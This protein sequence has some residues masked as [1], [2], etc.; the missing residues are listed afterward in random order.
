MSFLNKIFGK[1]PSSTSTSHARDGELITAY[2]KLGRELQITRKDWRDSVL[3]GSIK[4]NWNHPDGLYNLIVQALQ[5][6][7]VAEVEA[8]AEQ[9]HKI[10]INPLRGATILGIVYLDLKKLD[11]AEKVLLDCIRK[12]GKEGYVL[13][14]LAKVYSAKGDERKSLSTLWEGLQID[15]N[16]DN[17]L[18]WYEV[19]HRERDGEAAGIAALECVAQIKGSWRAQLWLARAALN[20]K[21]LDLAIRYYNQSLESAETPSPTDLLM[22]MSGDLGNKG[23]LMPILDLVAPRF[24]PKHHGLQVGNNLI[25]A[26][27]DTGNLDAASAILRELEKLQRPDWRQTLGYWETEIAKIRNEVAPAT[28]LE[29][30][31]IALRALNGPLAHKPDAP[32]AALFPQKPADAPRLAFLGS[33][34][35]TT[36]KTD[37]QSF[38]PGLSDNPGRF[39]RALP[40][41]FSEYFH[42]FTNA[43]TTDLVPWI[44]SPQTGFVLCG[45]PWEDD[46]AAQHARN[47]SDETPIDWVV[48]SHLTVRG[49]NWKVGTRVIRTID[50]K[51]LGS[52]EYDIAEWQLHPARDQMLKDLR[53]ILDPEAGIQRIDHKSPA[54]EVLQETTFD[55]YVFQLEQAL[56]ARCDA[57]NEEAPSNLNNVPDIID[58]MLASCAESPLHILTR[59]CL[60]RTLKALNIKYTDLIATYQDKINHLQQQ[61]P[62]DETAQGLVNQEL[63]SLFNTSLPITGAKSREI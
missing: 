31:K 21:D 8:A 5:D 29:K 49:E 61:H 22:Q 34:A 42:L 35:T 38:K 18:G 53:S 41:F 37:A 36:H 62:L 43:T 48:V 28:P 46:A 51:C 56:A 47:A 12:H 10:D 55:R 26:Y 54:A 30:M 14:N 1:I 16:Q 15:P 3:M 58:G 17:G 6:E 60:L 9:L 7:F 20:E 59:L 27:V 11:A 23:H 44:E 33:S 39:S 13:T 19:I 2:D 32:S 4:E 57:M 40:L 52:F 24:D 25:K 50:A 45:A 63:Q